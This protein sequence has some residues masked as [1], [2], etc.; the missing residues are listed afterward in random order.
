[1]FKAWLCDSLHRIYPGSPLGSSR[2]T[3]DVARGERF[4]FQVGATVDDR[5]LVEVS[6]RAA[7]GSA[8]GSAGS[9]WCRCRRARSACPPA[10]SRRPR[11]S[12]AGSGPAARPAAG[13]IAPGSSSAYWVS[14]EVDPTAARASGASR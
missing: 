10:R 8:P 13:C 1:M 7:P 11:D 4:S 5:G 6:V 14:C 9:A 2:L 3:L 12:G